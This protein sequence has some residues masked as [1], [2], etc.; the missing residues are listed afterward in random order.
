MVLCTRLRS[1]RSNA[2]CGSSQPLAYM[3]VSFIELHQN[4][5]RDLLTEE[6]NSVRLR[7]CPVNGPYVENVTCAA[8]IKI[9]GSLSCSCTVA[10]V[11]TSCLVASCRRRSMPNRYRRKGRLREP[12]VLVPQ[13]A[14]GVGCG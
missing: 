1:P 12:L 4:Q 13:G 8:C 3:Q 6:D 14:A 2:A 9:T 7:E 10:R 5:I 11:Q